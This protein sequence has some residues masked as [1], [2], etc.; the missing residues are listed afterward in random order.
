LIDLISDVI[1]DFAFEDKDKDFE[2]SLK[3][4]KLKLRTSNATITATNYLQL[5]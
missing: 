3:P 1:K 2:S 5:G 4:K